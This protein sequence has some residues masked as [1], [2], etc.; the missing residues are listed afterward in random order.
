MP[1]RLDREDVPVMGA[2]AWQIRSVCPKRYA[3]I[4]MGRSLT[5]YPD[6]MSHPSAAAMPSQLMLA[7]AADAV[8]AAKLR[9]ALQGWLHEVARMHDD[10]RQDVVLGV[11]EALA[12]CV[13]HAYRAQRDAGTM[14]L[15][16]TYDP[17]VGSIRVFVSDRG[18]WRRRPPKS[19]NDPRASRG[20]LLMHAVADDC[21]IDARPGGTTVRLDYRA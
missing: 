20:I 11:N 19:P 14:K 12:N 21:T 8:T 6:P 10:V 15:E 7:G 9:H 3:K 1:S 4:A 16:A 17:A 13:E 5:G 18:T 2:A